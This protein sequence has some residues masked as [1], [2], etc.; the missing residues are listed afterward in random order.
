[1][2][3]SIR[4]SKEEHRGIPRDVYREAHARQ[5]VSARAPLTPANWLWFR[6][7]ANLALRS[8]KSSLFNPEQMSRDLARLEEFQFPPNPAVGDAAASAGW[9]NDGPDN[10]F[11]R[12]Y[13]SSSF[14]IQFAQLAYSRVR[15]PTC[16][17]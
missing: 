2:S 4:R 17:T 3:G 10:V 15:S 5:Y 6:V 12:D 16:G 8:I 14:A 13:Y 1:M 11:Q 9:S 7:F